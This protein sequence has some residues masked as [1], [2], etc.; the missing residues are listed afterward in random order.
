MV[1]ARSTTTAICGT[2]SC[3]FIPGYYGQGTIAAFE[4]VE[5]VEDDKRISYLMHGKLSYT[6]QDS[7][8]EPVTAAELKSSSKLLLRAS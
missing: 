1:G 3:S 7:K 6:M 5:D 8:L 4:W 2:Y